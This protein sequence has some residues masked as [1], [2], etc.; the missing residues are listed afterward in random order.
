MLPFVNGERH[1]DT[2]NWAPRLGFNWSHDGRPRRACVEATESTTTASRSRS[3]RW[4]AGSTAGRCRSRFAPA[5]S[6]SSIRR[7]AGSAVRADGLQ[8]LYG[9]HPAGRGRRR[10]QHH[11]QQ[12]AESDGPAVSNLASA[13]SS[14][15]TSSLRVDVV[16]DFGTHFIIGR[17]MGTVFNPVVGGPDASSIWNRASKTQL[18]RPARRAS[19]SD[20]RAVS[21]SAL[22]HAVKSLQL[23][24][25]RSDSVRER[26]DRSERPAH[27]STGRLRTTSATASSLPASSR[28][29]Q[30]P[31]APL[32]TMASG[33][34]MD[35]LMPDASS[36]VPSSSATPVDGY[37]RPAA[38][39]NALHPQ[40]ERRGGIDGEPLPFVSDDARFND[41]FNSL[42]LR[43]SRAFQVGRARIEPMVEFFNI[44][45]VTNILGVDRRTTPGI[46][47]AGPRLRRTRQSGIPAL[48]AVRAA[49]HNGRRRL[50]NGRA[51]GPSSWRSGPRSDAR[52][53]PRRSRSDLTRVSSSRFRSANRP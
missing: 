38:E 26:A 50:R 37:S 29:G 44:F 32:W 41:R 35:I 51:R 1:R 31:V 11:R 34:P 7:P 39:L 5:T 15:A 45:N 2:N 17:T 43:L 33:V 27:W 14:A 21:A 10:H 23:R 48:F 8:S 16:H 6:S 52:L 3:S 25:R 47:R 49:R 12:P 24:Q 9:L 40:P 30:I 19:S 4:S 28:P 42:D 20:S 13:C 22:V 53:Q 46:Q 18:R 36:R